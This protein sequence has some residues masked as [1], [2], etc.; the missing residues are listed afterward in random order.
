MEQRNH[1]QTRLWIQH[2]DS[3]GNVVDNRLIEAAHRIWERARLVVTRYLVDDAETAEILESAVDSASR[4]MGNHHTIHCF[5]AYLLR[6][7]V[8]ESVRRLQRNKRISYLDNTS[9]ERLAG[10][11]YTD[12]DRKLDATKRIEVL[13]ACMDEDC[14]TMYDFR[15]LEYNWRAIAKA[16]DYADAHTAEVQFRKKLN[17]ALRRL[18]TNHSPRLKE[19]DSGPSDD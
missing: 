12:L 18:R 17:R 6:S 3:L 11:V 16:M 9:L 2:R 4:S 7:V 8:R 10:A 19:L 13:R 14:R 1:A 5:E 15:V